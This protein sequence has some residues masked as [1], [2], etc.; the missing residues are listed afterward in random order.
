MARTIEATARACCPA[1]ARARHAM[2]TVLALAAAA[3][4]SALAVASAYAFAFDV[5]SERNMFSV[6]TT[7]IAINEDFPDAP[8][9]IAEGSIPKRVAIENTGG[10][11]CFV[12][13]AVELS[14]A[15][16]AAFASFEINEGP[17]SAVQPDGFS[18]YRAPLAPDSETEPII[19]AVAIGPEPPDGYTAFDVVV[20]AESVQA[21]DPSTGRSYPD[22]PTAFAAINKAPTS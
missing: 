13:V 11:A 21:S 18:Y 14:D 10:G 16:A 20:L 2:R 5:D 9:K 6:A 7:S 15:D 12:R 22:G 4:L 1:A 3:S 8:P 19:E 17:W